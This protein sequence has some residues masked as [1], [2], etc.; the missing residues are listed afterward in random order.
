M[1]DITAA[2]KKAYKG[3]GFIL[4]NDGEHFIARVVSSNGVFTH[5]QLT[6]L[7]DA[8]NK[9]GNGDIA[10]TTRLTIELQGVLRENI[11]ALDEAVKSVGLVCGGT[12]SVVRPVVA[13]KGTVCVHGLFDTQELSTEIF[14]TYYIGWHT[15]KLPHKFKIGI[16]GCP[17]NCVKPGLHDFGIIGQSVPD[18]D[19]DMCNA[20]KK[21]SVIDKCPVHALTQDE[22]GHLVMNHEACT[23]CGK[24]VGQCNFDAI[25]EK[26]R[27]YKITLGGIW[28]KTQRLG[29]PVEGIFTRE[30]V[31]AMI[32]KALLIYR[33]QGKTGDRFG[34][35]VDAIGFDNFVAQM[36][37]D[38][39]L[40]RKQAILDAPLH[41]EGGATC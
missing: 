22:E 17:N 4:T 33:E 40:E 29:T 23:N 26:V 13:C 18:Y 2:E 28:G 24:C 36:L 30:Q 39:I 20:C 14:N 12:G 31:M 35:A 32:E 11:E 27:G 34:R 41:L 21:C 38:D 37:S 9:Y 19:P 3:R 1:I 10:M 6:V 7:I 8:A 5:D 25:E 15:V 16:G